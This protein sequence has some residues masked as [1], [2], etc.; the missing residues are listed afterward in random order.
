MQDVLQC[1]RDRLA[2]MGQAGNKR[3][4]ALHDAGK[5]ARTLKQLLSEGVIK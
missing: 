3:V 5:S 4:L 2:R 1:D